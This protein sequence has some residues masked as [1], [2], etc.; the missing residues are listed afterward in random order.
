MRGMRPT[1]T[2]LYDAD[3]A[4]CTRTASWAP[5]LGLGA[6]VA[7]IQG[8][9]LAAAGVDADRATRELPFVHPD[10][11]VDYGHRAV[12]AAL[13]TGPLPCRLLGRLLVLPGLS[14]VAGLVYRWVSAN[15]GR[16]PGGAAT[17]SPAD[18]EGL[19]P[20]PEA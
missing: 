7:S 12:A 19:S 1:G 2:M 17:C 4:F 10:G 16:L 9:D 20:R 3:C 13:G 14:P 8:T 11:R 18:R 15:R 6:R 5:Q